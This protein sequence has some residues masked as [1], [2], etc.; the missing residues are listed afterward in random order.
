MQLGE[1]NSIHDEGC[2][3][4]RVVLLMVRR[5]RKTRSELD[6][7]SDVGRRDVVTATF[8]T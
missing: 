8:S 2:E 6:S 5:R 3:Y 7:T 1:V 4:S